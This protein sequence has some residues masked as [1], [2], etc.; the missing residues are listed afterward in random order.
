MKFKVRID[1][2]EHI[3]H[4]RAEGSITV[5]GETFDWKMEASDAGR[6][7]VQI[8]EKTYD[9]RV[10]E[11]EV[12]ESGGQA[13]CLLEIAGERV[14]VAVT[15]VTREAPTIGSSLSASGLPD[16]AVRASEEA[17][18][19]E[20]TPGLKAPEQVKEG[21]W[22]PVPGKIVNVL[23]RPGDRVKE[24]QAVVV[25]EAMKMENELHAPKDA[26]VTSVLVGRGDQV[27][28]GQLLVALE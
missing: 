20:A 12:E 6:R 15:E 4:A 9:I 2:E 3:V 27:E 11:H 24:G 1:D 17:Q 10:I 13:T 19:K 26:V 18:K 25:L 7:M 28:R 5:D 21:V 14:P 22:A 23:V 8:G 16:P